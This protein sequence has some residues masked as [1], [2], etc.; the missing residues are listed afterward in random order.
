MQDI[1]KVKDF[2]MDLK[3][4]YFSSLDRKKQQELLELCAVMVNTS[5]EVRG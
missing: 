2:I 3:D 4:R 5:E 1:Q